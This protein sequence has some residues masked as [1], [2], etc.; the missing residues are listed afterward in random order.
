MAAKLIKPKTVRGVRKEMECNAFRS[1]P[2][3]KGCGATF[4][5]VPSDC[6]DIVLNGNG[7]QEN[8]GPRF[9]EP[10]VERY[11]TCPKC[12]GACFVETV[13]AGVK[14]TRRE[15]DAREAFADTYGRGQ[16]GH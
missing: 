1:Y 10:P 2:G 7:R 11:V 4:S 9:K 14:Y 3:R 16:G 8:D 5:F 15:L 6:R 13:R 12:R